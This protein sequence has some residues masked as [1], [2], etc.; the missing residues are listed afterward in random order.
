MRTSTITYEL[1]RAAGFRDMMT[2][3]ADATE[4]SI[5]SDSKDRDIMLRAADKLDLLEAACIEARGVFQDYTRLHRAKEPP[6][7]AKAQRNHEHA[8]RLGAALTG[9]RPATAG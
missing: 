8:E 5:A 1:R 4:E 9:A 6:D 2:K 3:A 7:E